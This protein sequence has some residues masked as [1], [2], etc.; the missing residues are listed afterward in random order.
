MREIYGCDEYGMPEVKSIDDYCE[1]MGAQTVRLQD[2]EKDGFA[3]Y[4]IGFWCD[5][6]EEHGLGIMMYKDRIVDIGGGD[7]SF[8]EWKA[9]KD[10]KGE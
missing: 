9:E 1:I 10:L 4:G 2:I 6:D 8:L 3:Y 7:T 5:W